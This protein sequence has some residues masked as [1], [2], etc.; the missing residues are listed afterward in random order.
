[1]MMVSPLEDLGRMELD[2]LSARFH[3]SFADYVDPARMGHSQLRVL[4]DDLFRPGGGFPMHPHRDMEIITYVRSG[5]VTHEDSLGNRGVVKAGEVQVMTA[6]SGVVHSEFNLGDED[7]TL[8]QIWIHPDE[9]GLTPRWETKPF[10]RND[11]KGRLVPLVSG[12]NG[13]EGL[14]VLTINQDVTLLSA[15][16]APGQKCDY[17]IDPG[18][19]AYL[20]PARGGIVVN[21]VEA[22]ER[23]GVAITGERALS[24]EAVEDAEVVLLDLP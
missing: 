5:A 3:F 21:G 15:D 8:F 22:P 17:K 20:I 4:N 19:R 13:K 18:R 1:M 14:N 6:G 12:V 11:R 7:L 24:I 9:K 2:W 10:S 23:A 16:L